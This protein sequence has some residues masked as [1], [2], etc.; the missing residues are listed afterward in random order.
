MGVPE[1]AENSPVTCQSPSTLLSAPSL[2]HELCGPHGSIYTKLL[3]KLC[4]ESKEVRPTPRSNL[5]GWAGV[6]LLKSQARPNVYELVT[7]RP[8]LIRRSILTCIEWYLELG[9]PS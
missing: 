8:F 6:P 1:A 9:R 5:F 7:I 2:S 4:R 3:V